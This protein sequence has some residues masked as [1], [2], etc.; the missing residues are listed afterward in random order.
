VKQQNAF[1]D[2]SQPKRE[3]GTAETVPKNC[4]NRNLAILLRAAAAEVEPAAAPAPVVFGADFAA[5]AAQS[6]AAAAP[7]AAVAVAA[8]A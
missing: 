8:G 2:A 4:G 3:R 5:V 6:E 1:K 7:L